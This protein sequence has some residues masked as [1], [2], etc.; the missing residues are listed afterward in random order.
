MSVVVGLSGA[1]CIDGVNGRVRVEARE[2]DACDACSVSICGQRLYCGGEVVGWRSWRKVVCVGE[3]V[4]GAKLM[5]SWPECA[6]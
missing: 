4:S 6:E 1:W 2:R 3:A 5:G